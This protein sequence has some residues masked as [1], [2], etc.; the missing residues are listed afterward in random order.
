M[1]APLLSLERVTKARRVVRGEVLGRRGVDL[2]R[3][4][5]EFLAKM[6]PSGSG[7]STLLHSAGLLGRPTSGRVRWQGE[8]VTGLR[9][10]RLAELRGRH[11]G[12]VFQTFNL[13]P[14]LTAQENVEL[15]L[16]FQGVTPRAR[17]SRARE[18]LAQVGLTDRGGHRPNQLSGGERQRVAIARAL[19]PDPELILADEP[20]GN[21]DSASGREILELLQSLNEEGKTLVLVTHDAEAAAV[22]R[23]VR[24]MRDGRFEE[25]ASG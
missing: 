4:G 5:G 25:V 1:S 10:A 7:K 18:L 19:A 9:S 8:D 23:E 13:I 22:A 14:T 3:G 6:G 21:L 20:T 12:F 11:I 2:E 17:R 15:P 24:R 16:L